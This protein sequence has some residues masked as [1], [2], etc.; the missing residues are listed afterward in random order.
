VVEVLR[1]DWLTQG[2]KVREFESALAAY[3]GAKHAVVFSSGT[4]AL[5]A[6]YFAAGIGVGDE[7]VTSPLTF[8]ATANAAA[9]QRATP[10]FAN[11]E[12]DTGNLDSQAVAGSITPR[13]KAVVPVHFAGRAADVKAF[14]ALVREV[15][16]A[17]SENR[18]AKTAA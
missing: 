12:D 15:K 7:I 18:R 1:S 16:R 10:A 6:A 2:P 4:T 3:A 14:E 11:V 13:T 5:Q 17:I 9:W 8:V